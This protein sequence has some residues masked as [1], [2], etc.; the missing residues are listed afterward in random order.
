MPSPRCLG[1]WRKQPMVD[2]NFSAKGKLLNLK[3]TNGWKL[4]ITLR[5]KNRYVCTR[6]ANTGTVFHTAPERQ[7]YRYNETFY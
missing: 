2:R 7:K 1:Y 5:V 3:R 6:I 4:P